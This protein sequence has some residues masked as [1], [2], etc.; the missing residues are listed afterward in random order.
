MTDTGTFAGN[1]GG[2]APNPGAPGSQPARPTS[3]EIAA[4]ARAALDQAERFLTEQGAQDVGRDDDPAPRSPD[5]YNLREIE[6][7]SDGGDGDSLVDTAGRLG[8]EYGIGRNALREIAAGIARAHAGEPFT[9]AQQL[10]DVAVHLGAQHGVGEG[11]VREILSRLYSPAS[12]QASKAKAEI[13]RLQGDAGF[14]AV[15]LGSPNAAQRAA[16]ARWDHLHHL[17][18]NTED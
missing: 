13:G 9:D 15:L 11:V 14:R 12:I 8:L 1:L 16:K 3:A 17:A 18:Y 10:V 5:D 4:N 2:A 6:G 7:I